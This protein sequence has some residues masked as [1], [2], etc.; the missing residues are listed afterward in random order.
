MEA[1]LEFA[2]RH[3]FD[4]NIVDTLDNRMAL[5]ESKNLVESTT[6]HV[7]N[8]SAWWKAV[9]ACKQVEKRALGREKGVEERNSQF[10]L[11][12]AVPLRPLFCCCLGHSE[13]HST[14]NHRGK[15]CIEDMCT[16]LFLDGLD[17]FDFTLLE[18]QNT[19]L[20]I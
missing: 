6:N 2:H 10:F 9:G 12:L 17:A 20:K 11:L 3:I 14:S 1:F 18:Q 16:Y 19:H 15:R 7:D 8:S 5:L 13:L 4:S